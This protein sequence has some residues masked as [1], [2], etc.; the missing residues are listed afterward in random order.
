MPTS[1]MWNDSTSFNYG[2]IFIYSYEKNMV[3]MK[4]HNFYLFE[5]HETAAFRRPVEETCSSIDRGVT[6]V[7]EVSSQIRALGDT[8]LYGLLMLSDNVFQ[9]PSINSGTNGIR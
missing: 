9:F 1:R 2:M 5:S 3:D 8:N 4:L 6:S 7:N